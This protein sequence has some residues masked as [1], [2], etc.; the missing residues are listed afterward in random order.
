[1]DNVANSA[2][3]LQGRKLGWGFVFFLVRGRGVDTWY[4]WKTGLVGFQ[5]LWFFMERRL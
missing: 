3:S 5:Q 1:M 2:S 4:T